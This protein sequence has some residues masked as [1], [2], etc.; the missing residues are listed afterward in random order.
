MTDSETTPTLYIV[1]G[2][3]YIY[4]AY[5]GMRRRLSNSAGL[6]T[7]AIYA[8]VN[9]IKTLIEQEDPEYLAVTF[10]RY[11][12]EDEGKSFR[13]TLYA[14]YKANREAMP[15]DLWAQVPYFEK[16]IR[17]MNIPVLIETGVEA[18][19]VIATM[20][21][22]A[23]QEELGVCIVS[24]DKDLMQLLGDERVRMID[25]MHGKTFNID[26]V[27][28]RFGVEPDQVKY[29]LALA[30][31]TSDNVPGVPGIG[32]K[33]GGQLISEWGDL[34][35]LLDN[36]ESVSGKKRKENLETYADQARLSLE[37]VTLK[38]DLELEFDLEKLEV[39]APDM[40]A[41]LELMSELEFHSTVKALSK[42]FEKRGWTDSVTTV[43]TQSAKAK[44]AAATEDAG[45]QQLLFGGP[46]T[47]SKE[48][49]AAEE[50]G[51]HV[52]LSKP[53][54]TYTTIWTEE[55]LDGVVDALNKADRWAFDLETTSL[56][57][58][59]AQIV[60]F[61]FAWEKDKAVYIPVAHEL[62]EGSEEELPAQLSRELVL[63]RVKPLLEDTARKKIGQHIKYE[64]MVLHKYDITYQGVLYDTM[65]MSYLLNPGKTSH[66]LDALALEF[67][68]YKMTSYEEVAGKGKKQIPF[69]HVPID[70]ATMYAAEDAD[71]T[72]QLCEIMEPLLEEAELRGL[73]DD[74][75][76]PL[77][78]VLAVMELTGVCVD[79]EILGEMSVQFDE[80][81]A[82]LQQDINEAAEQEEE[83]GDL[84]PNSP[85][86]LR[87]VLFERLNLPIKKRTKSG[88]STDSS[89]LTQLSALH[90]LPE[91]ILEYRQFSKL[92]GTYVDALPE[93]VRA[94]TGRIHTD[95][96]QAITAT[97]RLS[98][99][100]PNLQNIPIRTARGRQIRGAFVPQKGWKLLGVDY[101]QIELRI[102]AHMAK[103]PIMLQAYQE[104]ADIHAITASNIFDVAL[105]EV[106][107]E[108]R[109][110]GKTINFGVMYG[111]GPQRLSETLKITL[112]QAKTYIDNYFERYEGVREF[113]DGLIEE[114][115]LTGAAY[116]MFGRRRMIPE[117]NAGG[118]S[119]AFAERVAQNTP[120]QGTAADIIKLAM[121]KI[122]RDIEE[123]KMP[124]NMLL[125][126][127]DELVFEVQAD[128]LEEATKY[129]ID[130]ME[131]IVELDVPLQADAGVGDNWL[132]AK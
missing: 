74:M 29:V 79:T 123:Q 84:N 129:V 109:G 15:E 14:D 30:G 89:V 116:T 131:N 130:A 62:P 3:A 101:S 12:E 22:R 67:L 72:L 52:T 13:H 21:K 70:V 33:T 56:E 76:L 80:E 37:L 54:K 94:D 95:F 78:E 77:T 49:E 31:D 111:M 82:Q 73:H 34:E 5:Y 7:N 69:A 55:E 125:Q 25:T 16:F 58:M 17:A 65:L 63:S 83:D 43:T 51:Q 20:T 47:A 46:P 41:F 97:G 19:D 71:V 99:S 106:T 119:G 118:R 121:I 45:G 87:E 4:R 110:A 11:D 96:N 124:M 103:D 57:A 2:S 90:A 75:E 27:R 36:I 8:F 108:Q 86:Q 122:Q 10:D 93:L 104:G 38:D 53:D 23:L 59:D 42:W 105:E 26:D 35:T 48:G 92:K 81:L 126:V 100:N 115:K 50:G 9:M 88:P 64:R 61:A 132:D 60:G 24:A 85:K 44:P 39:S 18:D 6:P 117:I 107:R 114:A 127:H 128:F 68:A 66:G 120:I 91:L 32:E 28:D 102:M 40:D 113:F 112:D 98:S 1:D